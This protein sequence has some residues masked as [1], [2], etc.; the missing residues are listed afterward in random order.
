MI[1]FVLAALVVYRLARLL[2]LEE[3]PGGV[4]LKLRAACGGYDLG[5]DGQPRT[6]LGRGINCPH[7][8]GVW[9]ALP[10]GIWLGGVEWH[11]LVYWL[12][13]AGAQSFLQSL[14][15]N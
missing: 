4:I 12:A 9:L 7:C 3:G 13:L 15:G 11:S 8:I 14:I 2:A 5:P 10:A 1:D 6:N